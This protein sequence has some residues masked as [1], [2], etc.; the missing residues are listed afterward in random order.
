MQGSRSRDI[1]I[2]HMRGEIR[3]CYNMIYLSYLFHVFLI[4]YVLTFPYHKDP[5]YHVMVTDV[6]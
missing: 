4:F 3:K 6:I 2:S 5:Y 1:S